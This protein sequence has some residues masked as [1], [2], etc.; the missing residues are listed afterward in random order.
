MRWNFRHVFP[1]L[2]MMSFWFGT[3]S[4]RINLFQSSIKEGLLFRATFMPLSQST[5]N[6]VVAVVENACSI[7]VL[8]LPPG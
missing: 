2:A 8:H 1:T 4:P 5:L 7:I 6:K 3:L